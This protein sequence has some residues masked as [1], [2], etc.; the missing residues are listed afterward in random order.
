MTEV[1][2]LP[3]VLVQNWDWQQNAACKGTDTE[4]FY[5]PD[6]ARGP[7]KRAREAAAK[8]ICRGCPVLQS[9]LNW[10]LTYGEPYGV[11]GGTTPEERA[12][13]RT[14]IGRVGHGRELLA[15]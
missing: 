10:A 12:E 15:V 1:Y 7:N 6:R 13:F 2:D 4:Q 3:H 11:W 14:D 8:A 5:N 9:C